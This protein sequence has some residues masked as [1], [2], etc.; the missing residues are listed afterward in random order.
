[1]SNKGRSCLDL[2]ARRNVILESDKG[3]SVRKLA[4]KFKCGKTQINTIV[5]NRNE[6]L[7]EWEENRDR[8][9]KRKRESV[10]SEVNVAVY[11]WF[12]CARVKK[13]CVSG[14]MLQEKAREISN[15]L[16]VE[17]FVASN[18]WLECFRKRHNV[19]FK[20][21]C[22]E[23][24]D[25]SLTEV[26][27]WKDRLTAFLNSYELKDIL[28]VDETGLF[29]RAIP[30]KSLTLPNESCKGGKMSKERI[31]IMFCCNAL[32]EKET[33]LIIG[34]SLRPRCFKKMD[35]NALGVEW[36]ANKKAWMTSAIFENWLLALDSKMKARNRNVIL[37][38][39]N[40][41]CH[42]EIRLSNVKLLFLPPNTTS[43]LQP[44]DQGIIQAFKLDYRKRVL[45]SLVA[46]M[47]EADSAFDLMKKINVGD[48][49]SWTKAA[50]NAVSETTIRKCFAKCGIAN[51]TLEDQA[52]VEVRND[53]EEVQTLATTAGLTYDIDAEKENIPCCDDLEG[54]WQSRLQDAL[55]G[56]LSVLSSY[57]VPV[58]LCCMY[59]KVHVCLH[60]NA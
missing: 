9:V 52:E 25:V 28:N 50:W 56:K 41:T 16:K 17:N 5:K 43:H 29:F 20:T 26:A 35:L 4:E 6:I 44:L 48:A 54:D 10:F 7:K 46:H 21:V 24:G 37:L 30:K 42:P 58:I 45:R 59:R 33:P 27:D 12:K 8:G 60:L 36:H 57:T 1:M 19:S 32:G 39:D 31:T 38:L 34:K 53:Y 51:S 22:G 14:P 49:V 47:D 2:E 15:N 40:A 55:Y 3:L 13:L 11:E 18:G 23:G